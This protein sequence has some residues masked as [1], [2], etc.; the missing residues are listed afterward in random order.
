MSVECTH[1]WHHTGV[2]LTSMPPQWDEVCCWCG[3]MRRRQRQA[4]P[5]T[6]DHGP[7]RPGTFSLSRKE[8]A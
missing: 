8:G 2:M 5:E 6:T 3:A 1:C 7:H 4:L